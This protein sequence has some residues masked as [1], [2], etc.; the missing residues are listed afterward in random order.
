[1]N[2]LSS[3]LSCPSHV[4]T[5]LPEQQRLFKGSQCPVLTLPAQNQ[6][7]HQVP[8]LFPHLSTKSMP[9]EQ[10]PMFSL[11]FLTAYVVAE[12]SAVSLHAIRQINL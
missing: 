10:G 1:M 2:T 12:I 6:S 9:L 8:Q 7:E 11:A 3:L 4:W 5:R